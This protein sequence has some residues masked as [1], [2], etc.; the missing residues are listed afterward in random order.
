[1]GSICF[2]AE[3]ARPMAEQEQAATVSVEPQVQP[4]TTE[5]PTP[6]NF[7][8]TETVHAHS[9]L[10]DWTTLPREVAAESEPS[11]TRAPSARDGF[12]FVFPPFRLPALNFFS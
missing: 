4:P 11:E 3:G 6:S 5:P 7:N 2:K 1:M 9:P 10:D 8:P 12:S